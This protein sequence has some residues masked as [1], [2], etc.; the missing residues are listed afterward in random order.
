VVANYQGFIG[1]APL[2]SAS[3]TAVL[4]VLVVK[5][6]F[7]ENVGTSSDLWRPLDHALQSLSGVFPFLI[8]HV[9]FRLEC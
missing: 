3:V 2:V 5:R 6:A 1:P 9:W 4:S 7:T 8:L